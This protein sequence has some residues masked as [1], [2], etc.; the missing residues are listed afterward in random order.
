[1]LTCLL[2]NARSLLKRNALDTLHCYL[3]ASNVHIAFVTETWASSE[4]ITDAELSRNGTFHVFRL[5]RTSRGGGVLLLFRSSLNCSIVETRIDE[6]HD[7]LVAVDLHWGAQTRRFICV[8]FSPTGSTEELLDRMVRLCAKLETLCETDASVCL[9]GDFNL[10]KI[11]WENW[12]C[13]GKNVVTKESLFLDM[14][15]KLG[16]HQ[17]VSEPTRPSSHNI[18]DLVLSNDESIINTHTTNEPLST[19]HLPVMFTMEVHAD[20]SLDNNVSSDVSGNFDYKRGDYE[21]IQLNLSLTDWSLFFRNC[22]TVDEMYELNT[23]D[24]CE[25]F[26]YQSNPQGRTP[27]STSTSKN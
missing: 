23:F 2:L 4:T 11:C 5:D 6:E 18:L 26:T 13:P 15:G 1:M 10:P 8:Y 19:D 16:F 17:H 12:S 24:Y 9:A 20:P 21:I 3:L 14:C 27:V 22:V 25:P 7:E